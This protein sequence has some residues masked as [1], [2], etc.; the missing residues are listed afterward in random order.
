MYYYFP[1]YPMTAFTGAHAASTTMYI[2]DCY[3]FQLPVSPPYHRSPLGNPTFSYL[4]VIFGV[5][6][7]KTPGPGSQHNIYVTYLSDLTSHSGGAKA[8]TLLR[9]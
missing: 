1:V 7:V 3:L 2:P 9:I 6:N 5:A 4:K 8:I